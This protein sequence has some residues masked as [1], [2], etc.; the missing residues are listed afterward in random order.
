MFG[1]SSL[2]AEFVW[3]YL[4]GRTVEQVHP[5]AWSQK[6][7]EAVAVDR[8]FAVR[9]PTISTTDEKKARLMLCALAGATF[10]IFIR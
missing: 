2:L 1:Y 6:A 9:I 8:T 4:T 10:L 5:F 3:R 7:R